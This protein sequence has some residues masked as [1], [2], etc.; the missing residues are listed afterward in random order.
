MN[1]F[2][3]QRP[4]AGAT[5]VASLILALSLSGCGKNEQASIQSARGHLQKHEINAAVIELKNA[6]QANA[7][8]GEARFL[9]GSVMLENRNA[10][11][12]AFQL[13]KALDLK[14]PD[15]SVSAL[16]ARALLATGDAAKVI[17]QFGA[18]RLD[19]PEADAD[20]RTTV[21]T[22]YAGMGDTTAAEAALAQ[23]LQ[24]V[25][26]FEPAKL[27][28]A[29]IA[30]TKGDLAKGLSTV[31]AIIARRPDSAEAF[32]LRGELLLRSERR[33]S[34]AAITAFERAAALD[35][36]LISA[37]ATLTMVRL[38][39]NDMPKAGKQLERMKSLFP[40][41]SR[42]LYL[43]AQLA[44][45]KGSFAEA[46]EIATKLLKLAPAN[47]SYLTLAG[48]SE[49]QLS[50][51]QRAET[52]LQQ[53][54]QAAPEQMLT[55]Q[56]LA[57]LYLRSGQADRALGV[58]APLLSAGPSAASL[59]TAGQAN[60]QLGRY[61][62]AQALFTRAAQENPTDA[63]IKTALALTRLSRGETDAAFAELAGIAASDPRTS[64]DM[65]LINARMRRKDYAEALKAIDVLA[66]KQPNNPQAPNLRGQVQLALGKNDEA[67]SSFDASLKIEPLYFPA[68]SN[69]VWLDLKA[70]KVSSATDRVKAF[71]EL[72]PKSLQGLMA[73]AE[74]RQRAGAPADEVQRLLDKA[75]ELNPTEAA[76][77]LALVDLQLA[78]K[79]P[80][81]A[82]S[83]AQAALGALPDSPPLLD[84]LGRVQIATGDTNQALATFAKLAS[85]QPNSSLPHLRMADIHLSSKNNDAAAQS[86]R[87]ALDITPT[88][89]GAQQGLI[90]IEIAAQRQAAALEIAKTVQKQRPAESTGSMLQGDIEVSRKNWAAAASAFRAG[91][92][93]QGGERNAVKL[94][95]LLRGTGQEDEAGRFAE[96]WMR[97]HPND[98]FFLT[99][100]GEQALLEG[101]MA[102]AESLY[103]RVIALAPN[104]AAAHNNLS[105]A[106]SK[107]KKPGA[108]AAAEKANALSP[109]QAPILETLALALSQENQLPRA[110]EVQKKAAALAPGLPAM[111]LDLA[112]L[113]ILSGDKALAREELAD[114][115]KLGKAFA[116]QSEV[117]TLQRSL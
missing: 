20:L 48:A 40:T 41:D 47:P 92:D 28:E 110:V 2:F 97:D 42:T 105:W 3:T 101:N 86:L 8:S 91:L 65:A 36:H 11:G 46:S 60:L 103:R 63:P 31:D 32:Q 99:H 13:Q 16:L 98:A 69:L 19:K 81:L 55:R 95:G 44:Y 57:Q 56:L 104:N 12:A 106:L 51:L 6:L 24:R 25:P 70:G 27:V 38:A 102:A 67:K 116:Q 68:V 94:H 87:R 26:D 7:A 9:L 4:R 74:L 34:E 45:Q 80:K 62:D 23:A 73:L 111:R 54:L 77:R 52:H 33:P 108:V 112:K 18:T 5:S 1:Y 22:A 10:P 76:P 83:T 39:E 72:D 96:G 90:A 71:L 84:A 59:A 37:Q 61:D 29:R 78:Q 64:A 93:K 85:L 88:L 58:L 14:Y 43:Q 89:L 17:A 15:P 21:A 115:S 82:M 114:L 79:N 50:S 75:I 107:Q 100:L 30:A 35:P 109:D 66:R 49:L 117:E 53:A 113:Y